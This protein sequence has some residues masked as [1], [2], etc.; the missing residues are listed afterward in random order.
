MRKTQADIVTRWGTVR[1]VD[2]PLLTAK[3]SG[4]LRCRQELPCPA[5]ASRELAQGYYEEL[6][7]G[8]PE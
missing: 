6:Y 7:K 1:D 3:E 5:G 4:I 2:S 8:E